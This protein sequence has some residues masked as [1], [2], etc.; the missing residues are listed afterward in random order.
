VAV[1][2][3]LSSH[4]RGMKTRLADGDVVTFVKAAAGG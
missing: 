3:V 2:G 4:R 1:N